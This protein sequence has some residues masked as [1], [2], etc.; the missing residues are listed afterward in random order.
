[1]FTSLDEEIGIHKET[2]EG[3]FEAVTAK[4]IPKEQ[5]ESLEGVLSHHVDAF[6]RTVRGDPPARVEPMAVKF[7]RGTQ[8]LKGLPRRNYRVKN[9]SL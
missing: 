5:A 4:R 9:T 6:Q 1:M 7:R 2:L 8:Q 3:G